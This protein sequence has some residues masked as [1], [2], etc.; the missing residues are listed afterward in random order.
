[1]KNWK[2]YGIITFFLIL[3]SV[4]IFIACDNN[5]NNQDT[6]MEIGT[7]EGTNIKIFKHSSV[8]IEQGNTTID[9]LNYLLSALNEIRYENIKTNITEIHIGPNDTLLSHNG[10]ILT[11]CWNETAENIMLYLVQNGLA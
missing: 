1:M 6:Y 3:L 5:N 8:T 11:V 10:S 4:F 2:H 7:L 9:E